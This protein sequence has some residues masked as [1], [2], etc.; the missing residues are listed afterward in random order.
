MYVTVTTISSLYLFTDLQFNGKSPE[1]SPLGRKIGPYMNPNIL[2][3]AEGHYYIDNNAIAARMVALDKRYPLM[4]YDPAYEDL[5]IWDRE[6]PLPAIVVVLT[7]VMIN[8]SDL[9][10]N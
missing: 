10:R 3:I 7:T 4:R 1:G 9:S 2:D 8:D 5:F 6:L